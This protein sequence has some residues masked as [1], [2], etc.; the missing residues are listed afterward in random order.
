VSY[1]ANV[2]A[3]QG[4]IVRALR[5]VGASVAFIHREGQGIPD[6]LVGY[7]RRNYVFEVKTLTGELNELQL[8][9]HAA[10]RGRVDVVRSPL[11]AL[12]AIG[13]VR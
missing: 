12:Q 7:R 5:K 11:Q 4:D 10:W 2:D 1:A 3:N 9:W 8:E 13:A 6:L